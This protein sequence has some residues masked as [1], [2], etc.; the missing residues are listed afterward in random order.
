MKW[1]KEVFLKSFKTGETSISKKQYDIFMKYMKDE[2]EDGYI[3]GK[4]QIIDSL[5]VKAYE[6]FTI[7]GSRYYVQIEEVK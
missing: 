7:Y 5:K 2:F 6:W 3:R 1:F 4:R